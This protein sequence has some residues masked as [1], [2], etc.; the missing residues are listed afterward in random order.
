VDLRFAATMKMPHD[1]LAQFDVGLDLPRRDETELIGTDGKLT[2][3]DP[4]LCRPGFIELERDG[5][6]ERLPVDPD[7]AFGL[8]PDEQDAYRIEFDTISAAITGEAPLAFERTEPFGRADAVN[9]AAV[10]QALRR[11]SQQASPTELPEGTF[12]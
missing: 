4:W 8:G 2:I 10:L 11:S 7:G 5:R 3:P 1:V 6:T 12:Q 9:H